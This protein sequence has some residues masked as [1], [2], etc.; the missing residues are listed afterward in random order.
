MFL[1]V[2]P[3]EGGREGVMRA[4]WQRR[5]NSNK[6]ELEQEERDNGSVLQ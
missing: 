2:V 6:L 5:K 3:K 4:E 1:Q